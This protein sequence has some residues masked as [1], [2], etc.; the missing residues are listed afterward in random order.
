MKNDDN[1]KYSLAEKLSAFI[2]FLLMC[3][4]FWYLVTWDF[5]G[6]R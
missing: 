2:M 6:G 1:D 3:G 5:Y 4:W